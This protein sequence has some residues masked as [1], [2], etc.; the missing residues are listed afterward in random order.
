MCT[1]ELLTYQKSNECMNAANELALRK[2]CQRHFPCGIT[3]IIYIL[4]FKFLFET[5]RSRVLIILREIQRKSV[6]NFMTIRIRYPNFFHGSDF[7]CF[8][9]MNYY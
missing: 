9:S 1:L 5:S 4:R 7:L 2:Y 6:P 8:L 3:F